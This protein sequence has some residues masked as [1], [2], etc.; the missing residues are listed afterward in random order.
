MWPYMRSGLLLSAAHAI[1]CCRG[2]YRA[3][4][5]APHSSQPSVAGKWGTACESALASAGQAQSPSSLGGDAGDGTYH[6]HL[7]FSVPPRSK[8]T[9]SGSP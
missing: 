7:V 2:R 4:Q 1:N 3:I 9:R 6:M 8:G 5:F